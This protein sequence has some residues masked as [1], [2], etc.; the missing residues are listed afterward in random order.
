MEL[1]N[2]GQIL[3]RDGETISSKQDD[4]RYYSIYAINIFL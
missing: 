1:A 4:R 2:C 3:I